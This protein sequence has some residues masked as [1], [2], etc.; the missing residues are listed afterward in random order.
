[1]ISET[2]I[3]ISIDGKRETAKITCDKKTVTLSLIMKNGKIETCQDV[4]FYKCFG[5]LRQRN[6]HIQFLCKGAKVNVHPS[7][8]G[9]QMS[10]GLKAY[11]LQMG[12]APSL[13]DL[14]FIFDFEDENLTNDPDKQRGYYLQW[15]NSKKT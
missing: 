13:D 11:E 2:E 14:V 6:S 8:M 3:I 10:L 5:G 9:S 15:I 7:S 4:N 1:M 12:K